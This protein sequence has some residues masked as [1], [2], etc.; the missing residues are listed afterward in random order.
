MRILYSVQNEFEG[1]YNI[2]DWLYSRNEL[3]IVFF[4]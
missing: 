3:K 4:G 1:K 2:Y